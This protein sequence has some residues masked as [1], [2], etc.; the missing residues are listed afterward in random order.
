MY[1][2]MH[3]SRNA[4]LCN[5]DPSRTPGCAPSVLITFINM[6]LFKNA[7]VPDDCSQYMFEGQDILQKVLFFS[8]FLCIPIM[9]F[10]KPIFV[11]SSKRLKKEGKI[12]VSNLYVVLL[13]TV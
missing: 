7:D 13:C 2:Y 6:V 3:L 4:M 12:Y 5:A 10:G 11:L 9:L 8:A 1:T